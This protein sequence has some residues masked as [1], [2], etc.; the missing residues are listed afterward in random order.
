MWPDFKLDMLV[1]REKKY[2]PIFHNIPFLYWSGILAMSPLLIKITVSLFWV[3]RDLYKEI[4]LWNINVFLPIVFSE[5]LE[6]IFFASVVFDIIDDFCSRHFSACYVIYK[7]S[8]KLINDPA[9]ILRAFL[10]NK[11]QLLKTL[12]WNRFVESRL[13]LITP[14]YIS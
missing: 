4:H 6:F 11:S 12:T 2:S 1:E 13:Q 7:N 9:D 14:L 10:Y 5:L 8:P 3:K